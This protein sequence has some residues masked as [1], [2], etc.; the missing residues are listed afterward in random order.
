V[1]EPVVVDD[2]DVPVPQWPGWRSLRPVSARL[3]AKLVRSLTAL[4][5]VAALAI[6]RAVTL[7]G[8]LGLGAL[9]TLNWRSRCR[10]G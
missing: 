7:L 9:V 3:P 4:T 5:L 6:W 2:S 1:T 10:T 8:S